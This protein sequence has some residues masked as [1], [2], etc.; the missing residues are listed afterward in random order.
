MHVITF[1]P[2]NFRI[3]ITLDD[4]GTNEWSLEAN[5][6]DIKNMRRYY[7]NISEKR[8]ALSKSE[9]NDPQR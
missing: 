8:W 5:A 7:L 1:I 6:H 4:E 9:E 3:I 2:F